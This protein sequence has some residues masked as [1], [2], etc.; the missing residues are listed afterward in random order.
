MSAGA[1][2]IELPTTMAEAQVWIEKAFETHADENKP[3]ADFT[4]MDDLVEMLKAVGRNELAA[5]V[6][7]L[8]DLDW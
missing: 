1:P 2:A 3:Q 5:Q 8:F 4:A 6:V 7:E